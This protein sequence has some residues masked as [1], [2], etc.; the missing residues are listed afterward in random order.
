ML[1]SAMRMMLG[2]CPLGRVG[3]WQ[4]RWGRS[5]RLGIAATSMTKKQDCIISGVDITTLTWADLLM[6]IECLMPTLA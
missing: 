1:L 3:L 6:R 4:R 5:T 2:V